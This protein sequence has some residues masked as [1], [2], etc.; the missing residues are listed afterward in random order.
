M[1]KQLHTACLAI[2]LIGVSI[3]LI[4]CQTTPMIKNPNGIESLA[5]CQDNPNALELK[6]DIVKQFGFRKIAAGT[7][8]PATDVRLLGHKVRVI[9]L[10]KE[11]NRL[12]VSGMPQEFAYSLKFLTQSVSCDTK[13]FCEAIINDK[14]RVKV[15]K[16]QNKKLKRTSILE[17]NYPK[18]EKEITQTAEVA[19]EQSKKQTKKAVK[20]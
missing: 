18:D 11:H 10:N 6:K 8:R 12:Y 16:T 1:K 7:Y 15:Y 13:N 14:Q 5:L 20:K 17:C 19:K 3:S 4:G 9:D 2:A